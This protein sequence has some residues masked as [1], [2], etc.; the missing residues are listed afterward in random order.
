MPESHLMVESPVSF[1]SYVPM[2][3]LNNTRVDLHSLWDSLLIAQ[4][5]RTIPYNYTRPFPAGTTSVD[6]EKHLRGAIYDPYVRR[7]MYEGMGVGPIEGRFQEESFDWILCPSRTEQPQS[8]WGS[9]QTAL[10]LRRVRDEEHWDDDVLCPYA[11][12]SELHKLNCDFPVWPAELDLPPYNGSRA[13]AARNADDGGARHNHDNPSDFFSRPRQPH[14]DL[15][16]LDTPEYAG[17]LRTEWV[18]ERLVATAGVRLA[19]L[20]NG[21]FMD[22]EELEGGCTSLPLIPV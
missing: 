6:I 19:G 20:L 22:V 2:T 16:E 8:L 5:L 14:P 12:A 21:L 17:R 11:W 10:G 13:L 7:V 4:A 3:K 1:S 9:L 18:V 15:L